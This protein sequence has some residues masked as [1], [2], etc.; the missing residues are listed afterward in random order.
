MAQLQTQ[1]HAL[2]ARHNRMA[3]LL[4]NRVKGVDLMRR[5]YLRPSLLLRGCRT[6]CWST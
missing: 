3:V 1:G 4:C 5:R 2:R 6:A